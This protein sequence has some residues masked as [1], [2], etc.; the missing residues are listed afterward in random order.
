MNFEPTRTYV[1]AVLLLRGTKGFQDMLVELRRHRDKLLLT[2]MQCP[3]EFVDALRH[4][5]AALTDIIETVDNVENLRA[6]METDGSTETGPESLA[7]SG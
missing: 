1:E 7:A 5:A 3:P 4:R 2:L 6:E